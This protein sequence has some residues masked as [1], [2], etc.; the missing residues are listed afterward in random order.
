MSLDHFSR[1]GTESTLR[2]M[3]LQLRFSNS[4]FSPAMYPSSVVQ[5]GVKFFG[6]ENKMAHPL[7]IHSWKLIRP[8]VESA[9]KL[10]VSL[11]I[12]NAMTHLRIVKTV[13]SS[14]VPGVR[15]LRRTHRVRNVTVARGRQERGRLAPAGG[16]CSLPMGKPPMGKSSDKCGP[17][18]LPTCPAVP[19][20]L[21]YA[22]GSQESSLGTLGQGEPPIPGKT[23]S[24]SQFPAAFPRVFSRDSHMG[25]S[26]AEC[27]ARTG[28]VADQRMSTTKMRRVD[29]GDCGPTQPN[30]VVPR[31]V[32]KSSRS[33]LNRLVA[34]AKSSPLY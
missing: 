16:A 28:S 6:C 17:S 3:I 5:T 32:P 27:R 25:N 10:G 29:F 8:C 23:R 34:F 20:P 33:F 22:Q 4:G 26:V 7:P 9:V 12:L 24:D 30:A 1:S 14:Y 31:F 2:P 15:L 21:L 18:L 19:S 11:L 13:R